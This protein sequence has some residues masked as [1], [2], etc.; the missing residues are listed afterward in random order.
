MALFTTGAASHHTLGR[1]VEAKRRRTGDVGTRA[2]VRVRGYLQGF[3]ITCAITA[4]FLF[5]IE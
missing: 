5:V 1:E 3:A 4:R 2:G